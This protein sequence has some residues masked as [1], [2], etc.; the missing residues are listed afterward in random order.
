MHTGW[1]FKN[2]LLQKASQLLNR[3][4]FLRHFFAK[5]STEGFEQLLQKS[6]GKNSICKNVIDQN[7]KRI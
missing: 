3:F 5:L 4:K 6:Y 2:L 7:A 1:G